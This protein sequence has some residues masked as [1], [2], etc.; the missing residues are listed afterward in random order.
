MR[1][2][3]HYLSSLSVLFLAMSS[4]AQAGGT[5]GTLG[6]QNKG[7][8]IAVV[9][10][11][12]NNYGGSLQGWNNANSSELMGTQLNKMVGGIETLLSKDWT[13]VSAAHSPEKTSSRCWPANAAKWA[14]RCTTESP[15]RCFPRTA[16][17]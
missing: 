9:S 6:L 17:S 5:I 10:V 7:K 2:L 15:C 1:K 14:C 3:S 12:A 11:S 4:A 16:S 13:V 8:T